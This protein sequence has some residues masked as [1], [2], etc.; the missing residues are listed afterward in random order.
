MFNY[1]KKYKNAVNVKKMLDGEFGVNADKFE[2]DRWPKPPYTPVLKLKGTGEVISIQRMPDGDFAVNADQFEIV[3]DK[4]APYIPIIKAAGGGGDEVNYLCF[5]ANVAGST[6]GMHEDFGAS[7]PPI[8][9]LEASVD[10]ET[11]TPFV[12]GTDTI[13]LA[14]AGD[15]VYLRGDNPSGFSD[16]NEFCYM[17]DMT[18]SIAASGDIMTIISKDKSNN[19]I[20]EKGFYAMFWGNEALTSAPDILATK[21]DVGGCRMMFKEAPNLV[22]GGRI[23]ANELSSSSL[24]AMFND[25]SSLTTISE[26]PA[27]VADDNAYG[28]MFAGCSS[29]NYIKT[30]YTGNF[31]EANFYN[32]VGGVSSTGDFYYNGSDTTRGISAIPNGWTVHTF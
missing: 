14:N 26:L 4:K 8:I 29:L 16:E 32:W 27:V 24:V 1:I 12:V 7:N 25:C 21:I 31:S 22:V 10:G 30:L 18:G 5:T 11:W 2:I 17:F 15:K 19:T 3:R 13:T 23:T 28:L 6:I 20:P 9:N